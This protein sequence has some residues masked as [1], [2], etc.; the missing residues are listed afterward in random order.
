MKR[1]IQRP[2]FLPIILVAM[3]LGLSDGLAAQET[4]RTLAS[5]VM[6]HDLRAAAEAVSLSETIEPSQVG[7]E[8]R[9][10]LISHL[11]RLNN[12]TP[13]LESVRHSEHYLRAAVAVARLRDPNSMPALLA[14]IG[15]GNSVSAALVSFGADAVPGILEVVGNPE[16]SN[17]DIYGSL[18]SLTRI[19]ENASR[20]P[21][22]DEMLARIR[23][24]AEARLVV[25]QHAVDLMRA[26]DL[27]IALGDEELSEVIRALASDPDQVRAR[28]IDDPRRIA[29]VQRYAT[30]ALSRRRR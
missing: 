11:E 6:G 15:T 24:V 29:R 19:V 17:E 26:I 12:P 18:F 13:E 23:R 14:A 5:Q 27:A 22:P 2:V 21:L 7:P 8:L 4:Q 9:A 25:E 10:A 28:G 30:E 20:T 3:A 16:S 1:D